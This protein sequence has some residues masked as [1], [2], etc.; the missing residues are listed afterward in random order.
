MIFLNL[1][2]YAGR[3]YLQKKKRK[4]KKRET[5]AQGVKNVFK[6]KTNGIAQGVW[7]QKYSKTNDIAQGVHLKIIKNF[8][9][10]NEKT[11]K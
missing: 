5:R 1:F 9:E 7:N 10:K 4:K 6:S 3:Q 2:F 11:K 8:M